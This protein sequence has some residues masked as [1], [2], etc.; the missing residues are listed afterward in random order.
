MKDSRVYVVFGP[1]SSTVRTRQ[2]QDRYEVGMGVG[3]R[4]ISRVGISVSG[5]F[6]VDVR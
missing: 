5:R 4:W 1:L 6:R 2:A 3:I